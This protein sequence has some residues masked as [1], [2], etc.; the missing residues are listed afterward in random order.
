MLYIPFLS[1]YAFFFINYFTVSLVHSQLMPVDA[2]MGTTFENKHVEIL[3]QNLVFN[4]TKQ[5][6]KNK[7]MY[8]MLISYNSFYS[9]KL[10]FFFVKLSFNFIN[11]RDVEIQFTPK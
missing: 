2:I 11:R 8:N 5:Y 4:F 10:I 3:K 7:D 6:R 1:F 9:F